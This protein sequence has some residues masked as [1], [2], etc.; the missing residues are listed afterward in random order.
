MVKSGVK[1]RLHLA[2]EI[3]MSFWGLTVPVDVIVVTPEE[4]ERYGRK[5]GTIIGPALK[6]G[7]EVYAAS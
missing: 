3:H 7:K 1:N 4:I 5:V 2:Q 6:E